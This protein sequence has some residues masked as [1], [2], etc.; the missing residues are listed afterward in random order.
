MF[1]VFSVYSCGVYSFRGNNPPE[2]IK[3]I[4]IPIFEDNS[5]FS[6]PGIKEQFTELIKN[7]VITDNIF[8]MADKTVSDGVLKGTVTGIADEPLVISGDNSVTKR[9]TT[10]TVLIR[11]ENIKKQKVILE[12]TYSNWGEYNSSGNTF[13]ERKA[14]I[15][16]AIDKITDDI[17]TDIESNW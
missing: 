14:G 1:L 15:S 2:G 16:S 13:S 7:K 4:A 17:V 6:E 12:K 8:I 11:F 5:G 9:K 10:I 3:T